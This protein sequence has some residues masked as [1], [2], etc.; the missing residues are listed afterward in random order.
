MLVATRFDPHR[1]HQ[2]K[3][4]DVPWS[5]GYCQTLQIDKWHFLPKR[6]PDPWQLDDL[7]ELLA[8]HRPGS[9]ILIL[10]RPYNPGRGQF[11]CPW[12]E[13]VRT[14]SARDARVGIEARR[15]VI[16]GADVRENP[17]VYP[18][19]SSPPSP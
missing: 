16:A 18:E 11:E 6:G 3:R 8:T 15:V 1:L 4:V 13:I 5:S 2:S 9:R 17:S 19:S 12:G 7:P 14:F 10:C